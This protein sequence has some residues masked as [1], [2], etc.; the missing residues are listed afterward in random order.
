MLHAIS[1]IHRTTR[2][3]FDTK[4]M[5]SKRKLGYN[6]RA[7]QQKK[8]RS[9]VAAAKGV[10]E[11][12]NFLETDTGLY[13]GLRGDSNALVI[14]SKRKKTRDDDAEPA[15]KRKKLSSKQKKRLQKIIE[16]KERKA[17]VCL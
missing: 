4:A 10:P 7:R 5:S 11:L 2:E 3:R 15:P 12:E 14:P 16:A 13:T 8:A 9:S 1:I 17:Q 6:W